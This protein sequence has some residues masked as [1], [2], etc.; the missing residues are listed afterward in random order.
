MTT[1]KGKPKC[2]RSTI[3]TGQK[4][5]RSITQKRALVEIDGG[6]D[7]MHQEENNR[8]VGDFYAASSTVLEYQ[9]VASIKRRLTLRRLRPSS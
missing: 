2:Q 1:P 6:F 8:S 5:L 7:L 3:A 4:R 9:L